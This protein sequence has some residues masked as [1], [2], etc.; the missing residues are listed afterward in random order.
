MRLF[1]LLLFIVAPFISFSQVSCEVMNVYIIP[2]GHEPFV[3]RDATPDYVRVHA[4]TK[5]SIT[6]DRII[7]AVHKQ[8]K[9]LDTHLVYSSQRCEFNRC[10]VVV[11]F[12]EGGYISSSISISNVFDY[13]IDDG[14]FNNKVAV[15]KGD[16]KF[17]C[18]L[19]SLFPQFIENQQN[20]IICK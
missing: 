9:R 14:L 4:K 10:K 15:Y 6:D 18:Y 8:I 16:Q 3:M 13:I 1:L 7:E 17:M 12:V 19:K 11:D 2:F 20:Y 5:I